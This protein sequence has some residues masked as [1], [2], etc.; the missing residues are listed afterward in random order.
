[1]HVAADQAA[2]QD[3]IGDSRAKHD[4][5]IKSDRQGREPVQTDPYGHERYQ[6]EPE[7]QMQVGPEHRSS[8][9]FDGLHHVMVIA[10]I[11][12]DEDEAED[13]TGELG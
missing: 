3:S 9:P 8:D 5:S 2:Y 13:V 11:D 12:P 6:R 4:H 1:M 10:P 7:Q